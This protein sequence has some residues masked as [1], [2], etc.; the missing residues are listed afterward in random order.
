MFKVLVLGSA[1]GGGLPQWNCACEN[2]RTA[3][4]QP[5]DPDFGR[6]KPRSQSSLAVT[7]DGRRWVL[8]N[9]SPDVRQQIQDRPQLHPDAGTGPRHT[10]IAAAILTN[11]DVDHSAGLLVL[12]ESQP[13]R[14]YATQRV[15][16]V[17]QANAIFNV[18]NPDFVPR[19]AMALNIPFAVR[20]GAGEPLGLTVEPFAVP[21]K[22]ALW[23]EQEEA[24]PDFGSVAE[25]TIALKV[26]HDASGKSFFYLPGLAE[27][28]AEFCDRIRGADLV[29]ADGTTWTNDEMQAR[30]LGWK[31]AAR[32]GHLPMSGENGTIAALAPLGIG[33]KVFIH[34]NNSNPVLM[35]NSPERQT[36]EQEGWTIAEDGLEVSL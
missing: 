12:R 33:R 17:L 5:G 18:L 10:P 32:M 20:D 36:A 35:E 24:G 29:F 14:L 21:G 7:A 31:T 25:D 27:A 28:T 3:R 13:F 9:V 30:K 2:C 19:E 8:L 11:A 26:T 6:V 16:G 1:A 23:L 15:Q 22:V 34:I 4:A